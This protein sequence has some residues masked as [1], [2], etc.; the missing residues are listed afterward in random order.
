MHV[1]HCF[2]CYYFS[3]EFSSEYFSILSESLKTPGWPARR[4]YSSTP[5][6]LC[7]WLCARV[8]RGLCTH[9]HG[10]HNWT[11]VCVYVHEQTETLHRPAIHQFSSKGGSSPGHWGLLH[12]PALHQLSSKAGSSPAL[13]QGWL[14]TS[15]PP[16]PALHQLSSK[17]GSSPALLRGQLFTSSPPRPVLHQL[18]SKLLRSPAV[19]QARLLG[20]SSGRATCNAECYAYITPMAA[21]LPDL[22]LH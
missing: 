17:A 19:C 13:L 21:S 6:T 4:E 22:A 10:M 11:K 3:S 12:R 2:G 8:R 16:R 9:I 7:A 20:C 15:S 14:F 5:L 18:S 1:L